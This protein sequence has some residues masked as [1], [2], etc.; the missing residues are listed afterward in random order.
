LT[1]DHGNNMFVV[2]LANS[3]EQTFEV[4]PIRF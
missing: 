4:D 2:Y 3:G 1:N